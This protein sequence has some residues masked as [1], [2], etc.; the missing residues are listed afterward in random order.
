MTTLFLAKIWPALSLIDFQIAGT[1]AI[2]F[3]D[4]SSL[5]ISKLS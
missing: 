5:G 1:K 3:Y 2:L 4:E